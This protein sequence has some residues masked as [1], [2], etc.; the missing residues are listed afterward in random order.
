MNKFQNNWLVGIDKL[1]VADHV[2][3]QK[4]Q[5]FKE[6]IRENF[7]TLLGH[8]LKLSFLNSS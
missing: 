6:K 1:R 8:L 2:S 5:K 4:H 3:S 7:L